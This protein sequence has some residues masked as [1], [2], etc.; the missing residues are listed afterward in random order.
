VEVK[1]VTVAMAAA[2][3]LAVAM[4]PLAIPVLR[5]LKFGQHVRS[6]GP[7]THLKKKGTPTMGGIVILL[8]AAVSALRFAGNSPELA[9]LLVAAFGFG[10][11]GFLDDYLKILFRR[12]LGLTAR[13]KL[14][15]QLLAAAAVCIMLARLGHDTSIAVPMTSISVDGGWWLYAPFLIFL[16]LG[17]SNAINFAD[18]VD[19]LLAGLASVAF[20]AFVVL[21]LLRSEPV[22]AVFAAAMVGALLG[23]LVFNAHPA[24]M[25]MGDVGSLGVGG[26]FVA[27]AALLKAE[28]LSLLVGGVFVV[29]MLSV[30]LQVVS[31]K[32]RGKRIFKMSPLHHHFELSGW[33]EW[34]VVVAFWALGLAC[35]AL[36]LAV[37]FR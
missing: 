2:F 15:G 4:S 31:F 8:A 23:F 6:E 7:Q 20:G 24:K 5:R 26:G 34:Q 1:T 18:G 30:V 37:S 19:G 32:T 9:V 16:F 25:F 17:M 11:V 36:G 3:L 29:E 10:L 12:S 35:A 22:N 28:L 21:A 14:F 33:S 27:S 13:Q